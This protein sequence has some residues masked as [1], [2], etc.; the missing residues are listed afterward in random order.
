[1]N[2]LTKLALG[3][4]GHPTFRVPE[5]GAS[6]DIVLPEPEK[7]GGLGL[8]D[9]LRGRHSHR[10]FKSEP[11][12]QQMLGNLLWAACGINRQQE[13]GRTVPSAMNAQEVDLY[14][15]QAQGLY[16]YD[17]RRHALRLVVARDVR[18]VTG[19]QDFVD[20]APLD[21]VYVADHVRMGLIPASKRSLYAAV[22]VGAMAQNVALYCASAGL[23]N[24]VRG[25]F[26][27]QALAKAM[28]LG[29]DQEIV[30]TQTAGFPGP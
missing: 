9:A 10:Q 15:A 7:T 24:V 19:Y 13:G 12:G 4:I 14:L 6:T 2:T 21:L 27:R 23:S 17:G 5:T 28:G 30:L 29:P 16:V 18:T 8:M 20:A 3:M 26:D 22:S 25:W 11:L 1:M